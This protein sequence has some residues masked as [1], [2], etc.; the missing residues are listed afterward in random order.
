MRVWGWRTMAGRTCARRIRSET[1]DRSWLSR[2]A[3]RTFSMLLRRVIWL[4]CPG[5]ARSPRRGPC[6]YEGELSVKRVSEW[7]DGSQVRAASSQGGALVAGGESDTKENPRH[8]AQPKRL[9]KGGLW[10]GFTAVTAGARA[11]P[12]AAKG[13]AV[14][15]ARDRVSRG[16]APP[17]TPAR[18]LAPIGAVLSLFCCCVFSFCFLSGGYALP[19]GVAPVFFDSLCARYARRRIL[20]AKWGGGGERASRFGAW[21]YLTCRGGVCV[22][23]VLL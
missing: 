22:R 23:S 15:G 3:A 19:L 9:K 18:L 16:A 6:G 1:G 14:L 7:C 21:D 10:R 20:C 13:V 17:L 2:I 8:S 11:L 4:G 5:C 12:G